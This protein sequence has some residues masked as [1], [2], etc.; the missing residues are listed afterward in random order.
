MSMSYTA[1]R[2]K[3]FDDNGAPLAGGRLYTYVSGTTTFQAAFT[4]AALTTPCTYT[5]D[6][7]GGQYILLDARGEA[8]VWLGALVYTL[9]PRTAL[10]GVMPSQD[11]VS[12]GTAALTALEAKLAGTGL[13]QGSGALGHDQA[14]IYLNG[15]G[16][17]LNGFIN[18]DT[19]A[20]VDP[21]GVTDSGPGIRTAMATGR[22]LIFGKTP[23]LVGPDPAS[24][25]AAGFRTYALDVPSG[26]RWV[27]QRGGGVKQ[28]NG[29]QSWMRTISMVGKT[30]IRV[31]GELYVDAGLDNVGASTNEQMHGVF[32]YNSTY[33][34]IDF[35]SSH[36]ARGDNLL[37]GGDDSTTYGNHVRIGGVRCTRAG[38]KNFTVSM[39]DNLMVGDGD[40]DNSTGGAGS[41]AGGVA[42]STD[43]HCIDFEPDALATR[44]FK[45][46]MGHIKTHGLGN[47][48]TA[49]TTPAD[50]EFVRLNMLSLE[51]TQSAS[52]A[53]VQAY[54]QNGITI[55]IAGS[56]TMTGLAGIDNSVEIA[57]AARLTAQNITI[58][59]ASATVG[60]S[61]VYF[62]ASGTDANIPYISAQTIKVSNSVGIGI[63]GRSARVDVATI[64]TNCPANYGII[65]GESV[66]SNDNHTGWTIGH[67]ITKNTGA[68]TTGAA[69]KLLN[70]GINGISFD[71]NKVTALDTRGAAKALAT[72]EVTQN[73]SRNLRIGSLISPSGVTDVNW[74]GTDK[75]Y[76]VSG[77]SYTGL[78]ANMPGVFVCFGTPEGMVLA[79]IGSMA[80][81]KDGGVSTSLYVKQA[82]TSG[83]GW[84]GK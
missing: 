79:A 60:G 37:I 48:F 53:L 20:G 76:R 62:H 13:T 41:Y 25:L 66:L 11:G 47:D 21:T 80:M 83:A 10:G 29:A 57:Y 1:G 58:T 12:D 42:D 32:I 43:K 63:D 61:L 68:P 34:D 19:W 52:S 18:L 38:R 24:P 27:M 50:A 78:G 55:N 23:Y 64:E 59:G 39:C 84:V 67:L 46:S 73:N 51:H 22:T 28:A 44:T 30:N 15:I 77:G 56:F 75:Y 33:I 36:N 54:Q 74:L 2:Y 70:Y 69:V 72:F 81:R 35:V 14:N 31:F 40:L 6:G 82:G 65:A 3:A 5:P 8:E 26:S 45:V 4:T 9:T 16:R 17:E 71:C 49:G 7:L